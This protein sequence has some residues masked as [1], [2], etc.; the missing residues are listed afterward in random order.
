MT[1]LTTYKNHDP[2]LDDRGLWLCVRECLWKSCYKEELWSRKEGK[3]LESAEEKENQAMVMMKMPMTRTIITT[4]MKKKFRSFNSPP[5]FYG[6]FKIE[7]EHEE[8]WTALSSKEETIILLSPYFLLSS[9]LF[10]TIAFIFFSWNTKSLEPY[11]SAPNPFFFGT[12]HSSSFYKTTY[13]PYS[14][15]SRRMDEAPLFHSAYV[16]FFCHEVSRLRKQTR[17]GNRGCKCWVE[18]IWSRDRIDNWNYYENKR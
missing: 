12:E 6:L 4:E 5:K 8:T 11:S 17:S 10:S 9:R 7:V 15:R 2:D 13:L 3:S 16:M 14:H 1:A 18:C